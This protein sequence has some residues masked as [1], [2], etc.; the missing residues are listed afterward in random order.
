VRDEKLKVL[1]ALKPLEGADVD[2][3]VV[4]GQY[5][6]GAVHGV[7]VVG[8]LDEPGIPPVSTTETYVAIKAHIDT[9]RWIDPL[10][11]SRMQS[12]ERPKSYTAGSWGPA[13]PSS[14]IGRDGYAWHG[15]I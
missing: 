8:Y 12:D 3:N 13:A 1:R 9:W 11:E 14:L 5:R 7:P 6:A 2:A 4:R 15:E 10:R